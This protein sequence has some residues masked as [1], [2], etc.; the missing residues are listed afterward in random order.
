MIIC[1][2]EILG[3]HGRIVNPC[4]RSIPVSYTDGTSEGNQCRCDCATSF[5]AF[6]AYSDENRD[7]I[8]NKVKRILD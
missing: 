5:S 4:Q 7:V 1:L 8:I 3:E 6:K 2:Y